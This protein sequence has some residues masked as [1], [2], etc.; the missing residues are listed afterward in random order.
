M[1]TVTLLREVVQQAIEALA[2]SRN[3]LEWYAAECFGALDKSND[4][5]FDTIDISLC[6][7]RAALDAPAKLPCQ[8][9][10]HV[11]FDS[12]TAKYCRSGVCLGC[13]DFDKFQALPPISLTKVT[14]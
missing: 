9:C 3:G 5:T 2:L 4:E 6:A 1:T 11:D 10:E 8:M 13:T 7:L 14:E 12:D